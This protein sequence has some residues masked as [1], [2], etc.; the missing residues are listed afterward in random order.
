MKLRVKIEN[1]WVLV[2]SIFYGI[3]GVAELAALALCDFR[4]PHLGF[5]AVLSLIA[6]YGLVKTKR[7]AVFVTVILF[8]LGTT[9]GAT[10]LYASI[11]QTIHSGLWASLFRFTLAVFLVMNTVAAVYVIGRRQL[12]R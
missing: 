7:W 2:F 12:F 10:T 5:L 8:L 9:F 11:A 6:A 4:P 1:P 3:V